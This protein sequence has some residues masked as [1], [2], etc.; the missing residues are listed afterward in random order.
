MQNKVLFIAGGPWQKPFVEYLKN[1]NNYVAVVNPIET[2]T[3][4]VADLHIKCDINNISEIENYIKKLN[5]NFI[6]SDQSDVSTY[7]VNLLSNRYNLPCNSM[8]S[9]DKLTNKFSIYQFAKSININVPDTEFVS[10]V[11]DIKN[12]WYAQKSSI[13]IKPI[14]STNSRG[15]RKI[16]NIND[17]NE[18]VYQKTKSF[19]KTNKIIAQK[20]IEGRMITLDGICS[21]YKHKTLA[22]GIKNK[23]FKPGINQ[24]VTYSLDIKHPFY[25]KIIETNDL[26]VEKSGMKFGLT[27]S[28]YIITKDNNFY[29]IEIGG[30]GGGAGI[31]NKIVPWV[32]GVNLYDVLYDSILGYEVDLNKIETATNHALLKYYTSTELVNINE[33]KIQKVLKLKGVADFQYNFKNKQFVSDAEDCRQSLGIYIAKTQ[34]ELK[35]VTTNVESIL[36]SV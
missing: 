15:F 5:P 35:N 29:L 14:D 19:S 30:R 11:D 2:N 3:T 1:K 31:T 21:N 4:N 7:I 27:H 13:V 10:S 18:C 8:E 26:Y 34:D 25:Q 16:D 20:F 36:F 12:F 9:T 33:N 28:E 22:G 17:I 24:D 23:Y 6:T 32:S